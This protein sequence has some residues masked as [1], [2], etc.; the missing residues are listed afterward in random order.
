MAIPSSRSEFKE[1]CLRKLG[2]PVI[3]INVDDDQVNDRIDEALK[4]Y[5][6]YHYDGSEKFYLKH[7]IT[8]TDISNE[9]IPVS[10]NTIGVTNVFP[11]GVGLNTNN[12]FNLRY[13]L[14]LNEIVNWT[15]VRLHN[16]TM[17]MERIAL[18]EELL[19][20]KQ[21]LRFNR[22]QDRLYLD[23][24]WSTKV[25]VGEYLIFET[26]RSLDPDTYTDVWGDWWLQKYATALIKKQW[27]SNLIKFEG[28]Q[29]PGGVSFNGERIFEEA[30]DEVQKMED[31]MIEKYSL[32]ATDMIG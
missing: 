15:G 19:V 27:G 31:E 3:E 21:P 24:D 32:P 20:G 18:M 7:Q 4:F 1:F 8:A 22:H 30:K 2:K 16:Y 28:L 29:M 9:Y 11:I 26:Y 5:Q 25:S 10:N 14:S 12:L 23:I 6:D 17:S 13:Q